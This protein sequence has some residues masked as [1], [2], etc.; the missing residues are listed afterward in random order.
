VHATL[1]REATDLAV[2]LRRRDDVD[3]VRPLGVE[4]VDDAGIDPADIEF[5]PCFLRPLERRVADRHKRRPGRAP[6]RVE[7]ELAEISGADGNAS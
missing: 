4:H 5:L 7:M 1:S 6:P 3:E 2:R